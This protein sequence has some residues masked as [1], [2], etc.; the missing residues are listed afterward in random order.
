MDI[1]PR[2]KTELNLKKRAGT[3]ARFLFWLVIFLPTLLALWRSDGNGR[4]W[5][6]LLWAASACAFPAL[7]PTGLFVAAQWLCVLMLPV[8]FWWIT[9]AALNGIGPGWEAALAALSTSPSEASG[10]VL[11]ALRTPH[12]LLFCLTCTGCLFFSILATRKI[13][14]N[15]LLDDTP[16]ARLKAFFALALLPFFISFVTN[17]SGLHLPVLFMA[18]DPGFSTLGTATRLLWE[19]ANQIMYGNILTVAPPRL[20]AIAPR[21]ALSPRLAMFVIG[22]SVRAGG[23]GP[24]KIQR[25]PWTKALNERVQH[26]LGAWLPDTC[27]GSNGTA[28]SVPMLLAGL[29]PKQ[30]QQAGTAPSV[31]AVLKAAGYR[32]AW[33]SNQDRNVFTEQGHDFYWTISL[34][35]AV[36]DSYDEQL[37]PVAK[38]FAASVINRN[39]AA[40]KPHAMV[41]HM[42]GSHFEYVQRYPVAQF[43]AEPEHLDYEDLISLRYERSEE[44]SADVINRLAGLLDAAKVPAFLVY[45]SDH[46]ENLPGDHN[47]VLLHLGPRATLKD[48]TTTSFVLWNQAMADTGKPALVLSQ[49]MTMPRIAHA[50]I[51]KIFLA[52]SDMSDG[53]VI[54]DPDP[55]IL[56]PVEI[57]AASFQ[58]HA[59]SLL[60]P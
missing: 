33:I 8:L 60:K 19:G 39:G 26:H 57:G 18:S 6:T 5:Q 53:P 17:A 59:C 1:N 13:T 11:L 56:A 50:D 10:A 36:S 32:T 43:S 3:I 30:Y 52:L 15:A 34:S 45:S 29:T 35:A 24:E 9:Y 23:I 4:S 40:L 37:V 7:L 27:A 20:T 47:G 31:L 12:V 54:P 41:L 25:G 58:A 48:G 46:G 14:N 44:Y 2:H 21:A 16:P 38:A 22:E 42:H 51:A 55:Q 49:I 28:V